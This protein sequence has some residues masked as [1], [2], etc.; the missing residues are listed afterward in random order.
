[1]TVVITGAAGFVGR[2]C[3]TH[4]TGLGLRVRGVV[5][6]LDLRTAA[7]ADYLPVGDLAGCDDR[8]LRYALAG[9]TAVVHLAARVHRPRDTQ[10]QAAYRRVNVEVTDRLARAAIAAGVGHFVFASTVK[11]NGEATMPGRPFVESDP[12]DPHDD[13]AQS[14]WAAEQAL[15]AAAERDGLRVTMLRLPLVY[16]AGAAGNFAALATAIR[17]GWPLP[18]AGLRNRRSLLGADNL[19]SAVATVLASDDAQD[20]GRA[21]PYFVADARAVSTTELVEEIARALRVAPRLF[22]VP[23]GVLRTV[24]ACAGRAGAIERLIGSL[25]IDTSAFRSRFGWTPPL[26][27]AQGLAAALAPPAPL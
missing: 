23:D 26:S 3:M 6:A 8:A 4:L 16:G 7:R 9:A 14:K 19:A 2:A 24:G 18:L 12:P 22:A 10:S 25:E 27:L 15:A 21:I 17:R 11:V 1:M 20:R 13:Y 5:R